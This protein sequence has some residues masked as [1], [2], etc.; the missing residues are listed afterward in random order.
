[1]AAATPAVVL[2]PFF[3]MC[4]SLGAGS[5]LEWIDAGQKEEDEVEWASRPG[6]SVVAD[7]AKEGAN[8]IMLASY[9]LDFSII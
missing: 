9:L 8:V 7:G 6:R 2:T 4:Q 5:W 1:L 3:G